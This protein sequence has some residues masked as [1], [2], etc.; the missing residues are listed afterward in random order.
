LFVTRAQGL[1]IFPESLNGVVHWA[2]AAPTVKAAAAP[3]PHF[4]SHAAPA[5]GRR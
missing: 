2:M 4:S 3:N 5:Q 1:S